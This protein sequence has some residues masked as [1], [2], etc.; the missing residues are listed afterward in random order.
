MQRWGLED[1]RACTNLC[2]G[3]C[4]IAFLIFSFKKKCGVGWVV[5]GLA[6]CLQVALFGVVGA[7]GLLGSA[8]PRFGHFGLTSNICIPLSLVVRPKPRV[9]VYG[10]PCGL[11]SSFLRSVFATV[12][13]AFRSSV[14]DHYDGNLR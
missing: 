5:G 2:G 3:P 13:G 4:L 11:L 7:P 9:A 1:H 10:L 12:V 8:T 14:P 6:A